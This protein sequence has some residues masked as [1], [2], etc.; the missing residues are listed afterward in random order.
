MAGQGAHSGQLRKNIFLYPGGKNSRVVF[1][2][3]GL[4]LA[5][6]QLHE[7][8]Y[9]IS[10]IYPSTVREMVS[11]SGELAMTDAVFC[12]K[13]LLVSINDKAFQCQ[14]F[15]FIICSPAANIMCA[16]IEFKK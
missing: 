3:D 13:Y 5:P 4:A 2:L 6:M 7:L 10:E 12:R 1:Y 16:T 15:I 9:K 11:A 8:K 14:R